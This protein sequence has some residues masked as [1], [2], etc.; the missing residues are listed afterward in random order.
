MESIQV[1]KICVKFS[2][3]LVEFTARFVEII[4]CTN[5]SIIAS[6]IAGYSAHQRTLE[7]REGTVI[8]ICQVPGHSEYSVVCEGQPGFVFV[9]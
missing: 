5:C 4:Q 1:S 3:K 2:L 9:S 8:E 7:R 6:S